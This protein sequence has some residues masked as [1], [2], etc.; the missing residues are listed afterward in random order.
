MCLPGGLHG[1]G[2]L[3]SA[4]LF[5]W[6]S[7]FRLQ[8]RSQPRPTLAGS[9]GVLGCWGLNWCRANTTGAGPGGAGAGWQAWEPGRLVW[10]R[11]LDSVS[12]QTANS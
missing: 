4:I 1:G 6:G 11:G 5:S 7:G 12:D 8:E 10:A 3:C 9:N 2:G